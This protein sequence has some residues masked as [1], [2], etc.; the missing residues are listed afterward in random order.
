MPS[1]VDTAMLAM[2]MQPTHRAPIQEGRPS[3][4][5]RMHGTRRGQ[6]RVFRRSAPRCP[7]GGVGPVARVCGPDGCWGERNPRRKWAVQEEYRKA[8]TTRRKI[9]GRAA[10]QGNS[11][12][13]I[14]GSWGIIGP[15]A[16]FELPQEQRPEYWSSNLRPLYRQLVCRLLHALYGHPDSGG[17]WE[18]CPSQI[19]RY[20]RS[21]TQR[22]VY[23]QNELS[24]VL[25]FVA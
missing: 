23:A 9:K 13:K 20:Y 18:R 14:V 8:Q 10:Y 17:L 24:I 15:E 12:K 16:W 11:V 1:V 7:P 22:S 2:D 21:H 4:V 3:V 5:L 19:G 6:V 25:V